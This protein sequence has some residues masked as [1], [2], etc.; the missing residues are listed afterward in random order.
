MTLPSL[1]PEFFEP[2]LSR[3]DR[4]TRAL[5]QTILRATEHR[6]RELLVL[7]RSEINRRREGFVTI[8]IPEMIETHR[9]IDQKSRELQSILSESNQLRARAEALGQQ[10]A[11]SAAKPPSAPSPAV[12][13]EAQQIPLLDGDKL[14]DLLLAVRKPPKP[15][16]SPA[17]LRTTGNIW[18]NWEPGRT[19]S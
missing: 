6:Q 3:V 9:Q 14:R 2:F 13:G 10:I 12:A 7:L 1:N 15:P 4:L 17:V 18:E 16:A 8:A 19:D 5:D 11:D